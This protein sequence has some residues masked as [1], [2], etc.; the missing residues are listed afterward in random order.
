M[1]CYSFLCGVSCKGKKSIVVFSLNESPMKYV[2]FFCTTGMPTVCVPDEFLNSTETISVA[3]NVRVPW[4]RYWP[5]AASSDLNL[6][7][8]SDDRKARSG[9]SIISLLSSC[10]CTAARKSRTRV[11]CL[12]NG[13]EQAEKTVKSSAMTNILTIDSFS[14]CRI[15]LKIM[16]PLCKRAGMVPALLSEIIIPDLRL[17]EFHYCARDNEIPGR[18]NISGNTIEQYVDE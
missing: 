1:T 12:S 11:S 2:P 7:R 13:G 3:P 6:A 18:V 10:C 17:L 16:V 4:S 5:N 15:F 14:V 8:S 9:I